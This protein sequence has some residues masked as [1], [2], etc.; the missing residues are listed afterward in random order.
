[1]FPDRVDASDQQETTNPA[2][3]VDPTSARVRTDD[4]VLA[5]LIRDGTDRSTTF[6]RLIEAIT[7]T[8]GVVY[9]VRGGCRSP[10]QACLAFWM[11]VA[12]PNR[13]LRVIVDERKG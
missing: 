3:T 5:T 8:D 7:A 13:M 9:V 12:G 10:L 4:P 11:V 2:A 1:M 6:R